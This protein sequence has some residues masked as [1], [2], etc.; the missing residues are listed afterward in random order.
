[1][2]D[3]IDVDRPDWHVHSSLKESFAIVNEFGEVTGLD[4][5]RISMLAVKSMFNL[6]GAAVGGGLPLNDEDNPAYVLVDSG[7]SLLGGFTSVHEI[8]HVIG[9]EHPYVQDES[10]DPEGGIRIY[11]VGSD[12]FALLGNMTFID[13]PYYP[14]LPNIGGEYTVTPKLRVDSPENNGC[15]AHYCSHVHLV[16]CP[17]CF[18]AFLGTVGHLLARTHRRCSLLIK[19]ETVGARS[20]VN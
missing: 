3:I 17:M 19:R 6:A 9:M 14:R 12:C 2:G 15:P 5:S 7:V 8:G 18:L 16:G 20:L 10:D 4:A 11:F 13:Y 1:M